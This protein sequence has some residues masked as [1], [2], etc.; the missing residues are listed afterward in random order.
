MVY[1]PRLQ[2]W[3]LPSPFLVLMYHLITESDGLQVVQWLLLTAASLTLN[4][5][6]WVHHGHM[7]IQVVSLLKTFLA[8]LAR[9]L[10]VG[11]RLVLCHVVFKRRTLATLEAT[12]FTPKTKHFEK[13][14][15]NAAKISKHLKH[16]EI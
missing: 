6:Q 10:Q 16:N 8:N 4:L 12:H 11:L 5:S 13:M 7:H 3:T 15:I 1:V 9:E 2:T 14:F